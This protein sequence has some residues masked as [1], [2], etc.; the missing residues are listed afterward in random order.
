MGHV[1]PLHIV[2]A[3]AMKT[4]LIIMTIVSKPVENILTTHEKAVKPSFKN[5]N[6]CRLLF[7]NKN[8]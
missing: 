5:S 2:D 4:D 6:I 7:L 1:K 8:S 3:Q